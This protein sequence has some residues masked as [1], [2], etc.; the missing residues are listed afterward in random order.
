MNKQ[1]IALT[2]IVISALLCVTF[3]ATQQNDKGQLD[4]IDLVDTLVDA[5]TF[6]E[7]N[8]LHDKLLKERSLVLSKE[9]N[10]ISSE[11]IISSLLLLNALDKRK[12]INL[13][14]L[15]SGGWLSDAFGIIN[16]MNAIEAPVNTIAISD[17][18]SSGAVILA[19]G[20][21]KRIGY[22]N[23]IIMV[24]ANREKGFGEYNWKSLDFERFSSFWKR[25]SNIPEKWTE[26]EGDESFY[27]SVDQALEYGIIDEIIKQSN[28]SIDDNSE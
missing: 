14:L 2:I 17:V 11:R 6:H 26:I 9:V 1:N 19:G 3:I 21:G 4:Y 28:Q 10:Q 5:D 24:H 20:T 22:E 23:S 16:A 12:D 25:H 27:L 15:T 18:S 7:S 8:H 13:Y